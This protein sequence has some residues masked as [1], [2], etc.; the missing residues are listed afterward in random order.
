M[1]AHAFNLS[2]G[3]GMAAVGRKISV[4]FDTYLIYIEI[5]R[6]DG[7]TE[8]ALSQNKKQNNNNKTYR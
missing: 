6:P 3:W 5:S 8:L 7:D 2:A 1:V 4:S